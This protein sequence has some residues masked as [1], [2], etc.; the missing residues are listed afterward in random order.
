MSANI[1][2]TIQVKNPTT[3]VFDL[4]YD[5][6]LSLNMGD[7]VPV[8]IME[9]LPGDRI[10]MSTDSLLRLAPLIAPIMHKVDVTVHHFFVGNRLVWPNWEKFIT[11]GQDPEEMP[12]FPTFNALFNFAPGSLGDYFGLP[13]GEAIDKCS[14]I[15]FAAYNL[16]YNE[17]YRDQN[18]IEPVISTLV[19]GNNGSYGS[20]DVSIRKRAWEHDYF[21]ASLPFAQKGPAVSIP[22]GEFTDVPVIVSG[23]GTWP[24][25]WDP[26]FNLTSGTP[27][28]G[29]TSDLYA[30]ATTGDVLAFNTSDT[31]E[32][33]FYDPDGSLVAQTSELTAEAATINNLRVAFRLQEWFELNARGGSR[34]KESILAHFGVRS[35]DARLDRPEYLGGSKQ[36]MV[37]SEVLQTSES[38]ETPQANMAGHGV[39]AGGGKNFRYFCEEHGY[40]ISIMSILPKTAY[41]QGIPKHFS[42]FDRLDYAWPVFAHLGEQ[43]VKNRELYYKAADGVQN[44]ATFGYIPR[45]AEYRYIPSSVAGDFRDTLDFWH[46]GRIFASRPVLNASFVEANPTTRI[47]AVEDPDFDK[48]YAHCF[49]RIKAVR[50]LPKFGTPSF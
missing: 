28:R 8:H 47:Y 46:M 48:V 5:K 30:A 17:Y 14:A 18:L 4:S 6:K 35:S 37:I 33:A 19:D 25:P 10:S 45:Y 40:I 21:T 44:D 41:Q 15:P 26:K 42:K 27:N 16:I 13:T 7:L 9:C 22:I 24:Q 31:L 43:E 12:A 36:P 20:G 50:K 3:N 11:G 38:N 34:Y 29:T 32:Q 39:S 2:N 1:F 49:H 23:D